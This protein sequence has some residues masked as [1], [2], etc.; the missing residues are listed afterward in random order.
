MLKNVEIE[1]QEIESTAAQ[2]MISS[3][4]SKWEIE[5]ARVV[6]LIGVHWSL[7]SAEFILRESFHTQNK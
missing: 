5:G 2:R 7:S 3:A 1:L 4:N 6:I